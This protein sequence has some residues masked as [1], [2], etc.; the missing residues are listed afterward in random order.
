MITNFQKEFIC[1]RKFQDISDFVIDANRHP[2]YHKIGTLKNATI[3]CKIDFV[4]ELFKRIRGNKDNYILITFNGDYPVD[5]EK[6]RLKPPCIKK[7]FAQNVDFSNKDLIPLPIGMENDC[8]PSK[9]PN[10]DHKIIEKYLPPN[11]IVKSLDKI[12]CNF[13]IRHWEPRRKILDALIKN[14]VAFLDERVNYE[15]YCINMA[16]HRFIASPRG[17][18]RD[19]HRTWE[20]LYL[21]CIPVVE[22]H[23]MYDSYPDLPIVQIERWEDVNRRW[24]DDQ[25]EKFFNRK[26]NY[27]Q[28]KISYWFDRIQKE[29]SQL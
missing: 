10:T 23:L 20:A 16:K 21:G 25:Y 9:G 6:F 24:M 17:N 18:G 19:C 7:W 14:N 12:Y 22:K 27:D 8:G 15:T 3:W 13:L 26:F 1:G 4:E 2:D 28:L 11:D 29:R 5:A